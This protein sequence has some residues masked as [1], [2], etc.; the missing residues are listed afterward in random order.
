MIK[1]SDLTPSIATV[2]GHLNQERKNLQSTKPPNPD[3]SPRPTSG[4]NIQAN[5][6]V[7]PA[8]TIAQQLTGVQTE[9][10]PIPAALLQPNANEI[11]VNTDMAKAKTHTSKEN[12]TQQQYHTGNEDNSTLMDDPPPVQSPASTSNDSPSRIEHGPPNKTQQCFAAIDQFNR[13]A[14]SNLTGRY[15]HIS[16]RGNQYI[17]V[18]YNYDSSGILVEPLKNCQAAEITRA[19]LAIHTRLSQHGNSSQLYILDNEV[20]FE[21]KTALPKRNVEYQL[22]PPHVHRCNAAE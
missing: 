7:S 21:F 14:Y 18:I 6:K 3:A 19:W 20:S 1:E 22:V 9:N 16:S 10:S 15:P 8:P 5:C 12:Q 2:K 4:L 13:K 11:S 17:L